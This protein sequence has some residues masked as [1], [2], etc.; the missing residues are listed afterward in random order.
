[1]VDVVVG[2]VVV[3]VAARHLRRALLLHA[4]AHHRAQPAVHL[5]HRRLVFRHLFLIGLRL[6]VVVVPR[7]ISRFAERGGLER[8][9]NALRLRLVLLVV[10]AVVVVLVV[11][12]AL[13][14]LNVARILIVIVVVLVVVLIVV[15]VV[16][17]VVG[18]DRRREHV[19]EEL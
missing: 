11:L 14:L 16:V 12:L 6:V 18:A 8:G 3:A 10:L 5:R 7:G 2:V 19:E 15:V 17:V 9:D 13:H 1:M 4:E